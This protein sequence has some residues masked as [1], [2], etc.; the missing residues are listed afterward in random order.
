[1]KTEEQRIKARES[2][3]KYYNANREVVNENKK[4][5]YQDNREDKLKK[6]SEYQKKNRLKINEYNKKYRETEKYK[7]W[8]TNNKE[9]IR[10]N[11]KISE[12]NRLKNNILYKLKQNI[13]TLIR[14]SF[15]NNGNKKKSK[16]EFIL[17][18]SFTEFKVHLES[19][20]EPWMNWENR[21]LY[22]GSLGY[23]WD[24][25]HII[26]LSTAITAEELV[27]LNHY[28]NL[29]PLCSKINRD[30]KR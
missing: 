10:E 1:M 4:K 9:K 26:P 22:N 7:L 20:F 15:K 23:G 8:K 14:N 6:A 30:I 28:T 18:C 16:T 25:D 19:K 17:G 29:Q 2:Q 27:R 24:I 11:D 5:Y 13:R 21:G 3:R 12:N